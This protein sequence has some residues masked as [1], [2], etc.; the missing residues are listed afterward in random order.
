VPLY[1]GALAVGILLLRFGRVANG[2]SYATQFFAFLFPLAWGCWM[3]AWRRKGWHGFLL[4]L[5]GGV[6]FGV[7]CHLARD[8]SGLGVL[9]ISG[10][11]LLF[12][13]GSLDWF[14]LGKKRTVALT[15]AL[16]VAV[17]LVGAVLFTQSSYLMN[18][19][20]LAL[21]T[22]LSLSANLGFVFDWVTTPILVAHSG[23]I[24]QMA[25]LGLLLSVFRQGNLP[26]G[27]KAPRHR[28]GARSPEPVQ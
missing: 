23:L 14:G 5:L 8:D 15:G 21:Q 9:G 28:P 20:T 13:L 7:I 27:E 17:L 1:G 12:F 18:R 26:E 11:A 22:F 4:A 25:L 3:Y 19:I 16:A 6:P 2:I 10:F 24:I